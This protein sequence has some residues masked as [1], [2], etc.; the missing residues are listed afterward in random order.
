MANFLTS[1][2][3]NSGR[4]N[5]RLDTNGNVGQV[6]T[7]TKGDL[8]VDYGSNTR[9]F[10]VG[11][12]GQILAVVPSSSCNV[13]WVNP[14]QVASGVVSTVCTDIRP[15]KSTGGPMR[16]DNFPWNTRFFNTLTDTELGTYGKPSTRGVT[17]VG[18]QVNLYPGKY[19]TIGFFPCYRIGAQQS[20]LVKLQG[21]QQIDKITVN[22]IPTVPSG[23]NDPQNFVVYTRGHA[24]SMWYN[25]NN[26]TPT[27]GATQ[28]KKFYN[29]DFA[30]IRVNTGSASTAPQV[31]AATAAAIVNS[32][33]NIYSSTA[34]QNVFITARSSGNVIIV[35]HLEKGPCRGPQNGT[36]A[37]PGT[38]TY[39]ISTAGTFTSFSVEKVGT[40]ANSNTGAAQASTITSNVFHEIIINSSSI[41]EY[42]HQGSSN[43][44]SDAVFLTENFTNNQAF[45]FPV[46]SSYVSNEAYSNAIF[47][48]IG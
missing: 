39:A 23:G 28:I 41:F 6:I 22:G 9:R 3:F 27:L 33:L 17:L 10:P 26:A 12:S 31:A 16:I 20:R 5:S 14:T 48:K 38:W 25:V 35:T 29:S 44:D 11:S 43:G 8:L 46:G 19:F 40:S 21:T 4:V 1:I 45:G 42:Q 13:Q 15:P 32:S 2:E 30:N 47:H 7:T 34:T 37:P 18:S 36:A 24:L